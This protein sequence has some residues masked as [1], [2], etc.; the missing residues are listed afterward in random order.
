MEIFTLAAL[1]ILGSYIIRAS[2]QG[3]RIA[4]LGS[5]LGKYQLEKLMEQLNEGYTR[6]LGE[7]S[8]ERQTQVLNQLGDTELKLSQQVSN[9]A[10]AFSRV[11]EADARVSRL[12]VFIPFADRLFPNTT[13]DLRKALAIHAQGLENAAQNRLNQSPK[14]KA[15]TFSAEV[16]LFQH[17]CHWFCKSK[18]VASGRMLVRHKTPYALLLESVAPETARAYLKLVAPH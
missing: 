11:D 17:T 15:F 1:L 8:A 2:V 7:S 5:Y 13:F 12:P 10:A 4:L 3:R 14:G 6:A 18:S 16:F 9:L